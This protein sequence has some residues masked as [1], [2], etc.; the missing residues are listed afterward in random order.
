MVTQ[1]Y[2]SFLSEAFR[3]WLP[4]NRWINGCYGFNPDLFPVFLVKLVSVSIF[5]V[6]G[7]LFQGCEKDL[8]WEESQKGGNLVLFSF[9]TP[10]SAF[11]AHLS[12]SVSHSSVDDFERVYG[13]NITVYKNGA[14]ADDFLFPYDKSWTYRDDF[15]C[16]PG[17]TI[18]IE[19]ADGEGQ[20]VYA[21]TVIPGFVP[22]E[23]TDTTI[24]EQISRDNF[25][26]RVLQCSLQI[27]DPAGE[28]NYY[29]LVVLEQICRKD[30]INGCKET[31]V[32]FSKDDPVFY[33]R[34]LEGSL[35][36][37]LDFGGCFSDHIFDGENYELT[38]NLPIQYAS[39][40]NDPEADRKLLFVLLSHTRGYYDYYRSRVVAEYGYDLPIIDPIRIY[41]NVNGGIGLV[42]GYSSV[43]DSLV[44]V[45]GH[46]S[47]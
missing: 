2:I 36:G 28:E 14:I 8:D 39:A 11:N 22:M 4:V 19:A 9:L 44:F 30:I 10:D 32:N 27:D 12:R 1:R 45:N 31:Q 13:G 16:M 24:V 20:R 15:S 26:E 18:R 47:E 7:V 43:T 6:L 41:N 42:A 38:L 21:E 25:S 23:I 37:G 29:Q 34:N 17:D 40:P 33:V 3:K 5:V 35:I 46:A